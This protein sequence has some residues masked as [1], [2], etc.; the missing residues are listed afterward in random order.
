M[1]LLKLFGIPIFWVTFGINNYDAT[2]S[3]SQSKQIF[4]LVVYL[5]TRLTVNVLNMSL[6]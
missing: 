1:M 6:E 2:W 3:D 5:C 4:D